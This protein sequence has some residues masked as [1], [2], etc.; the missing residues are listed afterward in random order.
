M[1]STEIRK[2]AIEVFGATS[3][4]DA[5]LALD[6]FQEV[7]GATDLETSIPHLICDGFD[8]AQT[9]A[10]IAMGAAGL[11]DDARFCQ[12]LNKWRDVA[13][14]MVEKGAPSIER[15]GYDPVDLG[16]AFHD[17]KLYYPVQ[18]LVRT[19]SFDASGYKK[20]SEHVDVVVVRSDRTLLNVQ[21]STDQSG[22][23]S[24]IIRLTDGTL[25]QKR[26]TASPYS[27]WEWASIQ[28][29]LSG[30]YSKKSLQLLAARMHQHLMSRVWLPDQNDYWLLTCAAIT[31]YIQAIFDAVP[32]IL[33][34]GSPGTGK[35]ELGAGMTEISCNAVMIGQSSP[36][37]MLRVMDEGRGLTVIDDLE[38]IG[39]KGGVAGKEKFSE[40][41]QLL[42][43]SYKKSSAT[44]IVTNSK[45]RTEVMNFFGVKVISNTMGVDAILGSR[46]L[47]IS[48]GSI[49]KSQIGQ[50]LT[51]QGLS[52]DEL[53]SLKND[54][55]IWAFDNV[56]LI[57]NAYQEAVKGSSE[58]DEE[59][60]APLRVL[61]RMMN[62]PEAIEAVEKA[63]EDQV[64]K[65]NPSAS[66]EE[67]LRVIMDKLLED[68]AQELTITE[69]S[70][71]LRRHM[72]VKV[73]PKNKMLWMKPEWISKKIRAMGYIDENSGRKNLYGYQMRVVSI[74]KEKRLELQ[75]FSNGKRNPYAFCSGCMGC[76]YKA[77][78]CEIMPYRVAKEGL[79]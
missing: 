9:Q 36:P 44:K 42:K 58:R 73:N 13:R 46:M 47:H 62:I 11:T 29:Y 31:S 52:T 19:E 12:H 57:S 34:K 8:E 17:G 63:L 76:P 60:A 77:L 25:L 7:T 75:A 39:V 59:I 35:S 5:L 15:S 37:T 16:S 56:E 70:L 1:K 43:T 71:L 33:L 64:N 54:L 55:H 68:G 30:A 23:G 26:P 49:P 10:L 24:G 2:K 72:S 61:A 67:A 79:L 69:I 51:R 14:E 22:K 27:S 40:M 38:S 20:H 53:T 78:G 48:T 28:R 65:K 4:A 41:V 50:F 18:T 66:P 45:R 3:A 21:E 32:L 74:S 6:F